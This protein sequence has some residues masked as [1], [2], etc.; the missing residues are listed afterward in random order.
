MKNLKIFVVLLVFL[1]TMSGCTVLEIIMGRPDPED[2]LAKI[3]DV[4]Y[5][6]ID[7]LKF[8]AKVKLIENQ[9]EVDISE[10]DLV[11]QGKIDKTDEDNVIGEYLAEGSA[12]YEGEKFEG[13]AGLKVLSK[14][15]AYLTIS[16]EI[17]AK[18]IENRPLVTSMMNL[19]KLK[20][21]WLKM[22]TPEEL[23]GAPVEEPVSDVEEA[24]TEEQQKQLEQ[25]YKE[26]TF[27]IIV[28]ELDDEK[29]DS[30]STYHYKVNINKEDIM[31][32]F[33]KSAEIFEEPMT[34]DEKEDLEK[35]LTTFSENPSEVWIGKKDNYIYKCT[36]RLHIKEQGYDLT[37]DVE[38]KLF[39][40][41]KQVEVTAPDPSEIVEQTDLYEGIGSGLRDLDE[42]EEVSEEIDLEDYVTEE[43]V[44]KMMEEL[45]KIKRKR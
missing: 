33:V 23:M 10:A 30:V 43:E 24:L 16:D 20:G 8:E 27:L 1:F 36:S 5:E 12:T 26:T 13:G 17:L 39:D 28:E 41:N 6:G 35:T 19:N 29:I 45:P 31:N 22:D 2:V 4:Y 3:D 40:Y 34:V 14:N 15:L 25:L 32:F 44:E 7:T 38:L 11:V 9:S 37:L 42:L 21:K 18:L